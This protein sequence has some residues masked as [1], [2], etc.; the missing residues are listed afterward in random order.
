MNTAN[1]DASRQLLTA[2]GWVAAA[3]VTCFVVGLSAGVA[4]GVFWAKS[5][6]IDNCNTIGWI[7]YQ[8]HT[9][10][11]TY[12]TGED[13]PVFDEASASQEAKVTSVRS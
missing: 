2:L 6:W 12:W 5:T 9:Y 7:A 1:I 3:S 8:G 13:E 4:A 10:E 11:C